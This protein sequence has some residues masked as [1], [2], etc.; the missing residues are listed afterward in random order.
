MPIGK[1]EVKITK[2]YT[3]EADEY[4]VEH[5]PTPNWSE[6]QTP[7]TGPNSFEVRFEAEAGADIV[8]S[9]ATYDV[10]IQVVCLTNPGAPRGIGNLGDPGTPQ[11]AAEA[12]AGWEYHSSGD[13]HK[14]QWKFLFPTAALQAAGADRETNQIYQVYVTLI[15]SAAGAKKIGCFAASEPFLLPG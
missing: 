2:V 10:Y 14:K 4:S 8:A 11:L 9:G 13:S 6:N 3:V 5:D 7:V 12:F 15:D 1:N